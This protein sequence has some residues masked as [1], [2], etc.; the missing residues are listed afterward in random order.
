MKGEV[1]AA[2]NVEAAGKGL[3]ASKG[4]SRYPLL[5]SGVLQLLR[6]QGEINIEHP[7]FRNDRVSLL[8]FRYRN[9]KEPDRPLFLKVKVACH[10]AHVFCSL[11]PVH[12]LSHLLAGL[13]HEPL[14]M[15]DTG[16]KTVTL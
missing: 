1:E 12:R 10:N 4:V 14:G 7:R 11:G 3:D 15:G 9:W 16:I 8:L 2:G 5:P 13:N 6:A